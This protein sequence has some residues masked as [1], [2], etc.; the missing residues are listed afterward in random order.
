MTE[1]KLVL[2]GKLDSGIDGLS[3]TG[4]KNN[5]YVGLGAG[6]S[7]SLGGNNAFVGAYSGANA[8]AEAS[9]FLGVRSGR[10]AK[11]A[12][13]SVFI[14][15]KAGERA[16]RVD[17]SICIGPY[18]GQ[19]MKRANNNTIVGYQAGAELTSGSRNTVVGS[20]AAFQQFNGHDNV[21]IGH[22]AGYRNQI[23]ANNCYVG[24]NSGFAAVS[25]FE[26]VCLGVG[27]GQF[28]TAGTKNVL[29][30][31][32]AGNAISVA[33]NCIA[34]GTRAMEFFANGDTN[35]CLGTETAR[36]LSGNNNT[37][38]GGYTASNASGSFNTVVGS[39]SM[40]RTNNWR[41]DLENSVIVGENVKFNIPINV[42]G[43]TYE[44]ALTVPTATYTPPSWSTQ[45]LATGAVGTLYSQQVAASSDVGSTLVYSKVGTS[46]PWVAVSSSGLVTGSPK[47]LG[48]TLSDDTTQTMSIVVRATDQQGL[49][50]DVTFDVD[51]TSSLPTYNLNTWKINGGTMNT[52][53][54]TGKSYYI[55]MIWSSDSY[56]L[57]FTPL[58]TT[59]YGTLTTLNS[60]TCRV[61]GTAPS[62]GFYADFFQYRV[63]DQEYQFEAYTLDIDVV[64]ATFEPDYYTIG[65]IPAYS[66]SVTV[67]YTAYRTVYYPVYYTA[68]RT[69]YYTAY[70][71][72]NT[73]QTYDR[74]YNY[75][76]DGYGYLDQGPYSI[77]QY[78]GENYASGGYHIGYWYTA[79]QVT[80]SYQEA[81]T[82]SY[83]QAYTE[84]YQSSYQEAYTDTYQQTTNVAQ[85]NVS[86]TYYSNADVYEYDPNG[87]YR[88]GYMSGGFTQGRQ[89]N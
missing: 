65:T 57:T 38:L 37:I 48:T 54:V 59:Q 47:W 32:L 49:V 88:A 77:P 72:V 29:C 74:Y 82:E 56:P 42:V 71:T 24:T 17:S 19:K 40:N 55:D 45:A 11:L 84:S 8:T 2:S 7:A 61:S 35:T 52:P 36:R 58:T 69:V 18:S 63:R 27:S 34:I 66:Y 80:G 13:E 33:S 75:Y 78:P 46:P 26:N 16:E 73:Y 6:A 60:T 21:C 64:E 67:Y 62:A 9:V 15:Y 12:K 79:S 1:R 41:V 85:H 87:G 31:F 70:R 83:Q 20:F 51:I 53:I 81:Y 10:V 3:L 50:S 89:T 39:R 4:G 86:G 5:T 28:L 22:R 30:G 44:D 23:G 25:G 68:Y 14:G 43:L 76:I